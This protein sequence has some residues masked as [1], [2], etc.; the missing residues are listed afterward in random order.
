VKYQIKP[1]FRACQILAGLLKVLS[2]I[3]D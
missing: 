1:C 3:D 2:T